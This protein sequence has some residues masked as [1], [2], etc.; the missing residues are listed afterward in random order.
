MT[1]WKR[2]DE[3]AANAYH[4]SIQQSDTDD[5]GTDQDDNSST[6]TD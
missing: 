6:H 3:E 4:Q 2:D 1:H 5:D